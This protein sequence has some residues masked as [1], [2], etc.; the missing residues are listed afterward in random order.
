MKFRRCVTWCVDNL[1]LIHG[2]GASN[3]S[4]AYV[5][6]L[7]SSYCQI[8]SPNYVI[9]QEPEDLINNIVNEI[10]DVF[11]DQP[12]TLVGHSFGG[13]IGAFICSSGKVNARNLVTA[14]TPWAG[15]RFAKWLGM[16]NPSNLLF[17]NMNPGSDLIQKL[18]QIEWHG[19]HTNLVLHGGGNKFAGLGGYENDGTVSVV[20]QES[21]PPGFVNTIHNRVNVSHAEILQHPQ[22]Q[23]TILHH[24]KLDNQESQDL[25]VI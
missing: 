5:R 17:T 18:S 12:V 8:L 6:H 15:S 19:K 25:V 1:V 3:L 14:G 24:L 11:G 22:L 10:L 9:D 23:R 20:S 16:M 7:L 2:A 4:F 21:S 13:I